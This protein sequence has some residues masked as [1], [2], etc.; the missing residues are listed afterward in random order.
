MGVY[1]VP[2]V[3]GLMKDAIQLAEDWLLDPKHYVGQET[4]HMPL[5]GFGDVCGNGVT[6][7]QCELCRLSL[8]LSSYA[9]E[10]S[11]K[12]TRRC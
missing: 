7:P 10:L 11:L 4:K 6:N 8:L 1:Y 12:M 9:R 5:G 3:Q 2:D